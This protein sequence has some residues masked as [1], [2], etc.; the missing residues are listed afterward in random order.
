MMGIRTWSA[1]LLLLAMAALTACG[2][3]HWTKAGADADAGR[4]D[5]ADCR[6]QGR[7]L[8]ER[9]ANIESDIFATRSRDWA[10]SGSLGVK[11]ANASAMDRSREQHYVEDC[12]RAKGYAPRH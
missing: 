1:L 6:Q 3:S 12:M 4:A 7:A 2:T 11:E 10:L 9:D 5:L 8:V